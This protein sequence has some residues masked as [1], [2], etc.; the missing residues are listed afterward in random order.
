MFDIR[1]VGAGGGSIAGSTRATRSGWGRKAPPRTRAPACYRR[2][3]T[4]PAV[5]DANLIF[6]RLHP[7]LGCKFTLE[8]EA[9][10]CAIDGVARAIGLSRIETAE[11]IIR[12]S[13]EAVAQAVKSVAVDRARDPRDYVLASFGGAGPMHACF[14]A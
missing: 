9:A 4:E 10:E 11:G 12:I 13:C 14:V 8:T 5:T 2:G 3:G 7:S 1:N 6:G